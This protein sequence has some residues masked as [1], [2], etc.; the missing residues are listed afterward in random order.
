MSLSVFDAAMPLLDDLAKC[1]KPQD[2]WQIK[3]EQIEAKINDFQ[4]LYQSANDREMFESSLYALVATVDERLIAHPTWG[5]AWQQQTLVQ[6][7]FN[8]TNAGCHFFEKLEKLQKNKD[9][10]KEALA[11]FLV[12]LKFGFEGKLKLQ[13]AYEKQQLLQELQDTCKFASLNLHQHIPP[14]ASPVTPCF[15]VKSYRPLMYLSGGLVC[16]LLLL[17]VV[18]FVSLTQLERKT[19]HL[20]S[21]LAPLL[22]KKLI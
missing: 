3:R 20:Q 4:R 11:I 16:L 12:C 7:Y 9:K 10:N 22:A 21:R 14:I 15:D 5:E 6:Q 13:S 1:C 8:D 19:H 18:N 2:T 17:H